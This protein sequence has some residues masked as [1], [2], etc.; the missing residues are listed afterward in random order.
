MYTYN[1]FF[2]DSDTAENSVFSSAKQ[3]PIRLQYGIIEMI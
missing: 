1:I 3:P 2:E